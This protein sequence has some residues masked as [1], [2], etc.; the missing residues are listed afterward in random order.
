MGCIV[1][2]AIKAKSSTATSWIES[3]FSLPHGNRRFGRQGLADARE[4]V[5]RKKKRR[6]PTVPSRDASVGE[7]KNV[8][9]MNAMRCICVAIENDF[10]SKTD[11]R[12][13]RGTYRQTTPSHRQTRIEGD[14][15]IQVSSAHPE[16]R[17]ESTSSS[18]QPATLF[19]GHSRLDSRGGS[20]YFAHADHFSYLSKG[21]C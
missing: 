21:L 11:C 13:A 18:S 1:G 2:R 16:N 20:Q 6:W 10:E 3:R 9:I 5:N 19:L 7:I 12:C 4:S 8:Q 15:E 14:C 17:I